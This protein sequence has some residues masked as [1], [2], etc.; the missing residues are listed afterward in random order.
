MTLKICGGEIV[1]PAGDKSGKL[2]ILIEDGRIKAIG[3]DL[4]EASQTIDAGGKMIF[5]G[6]IDIHCHLREPGQEY[7]EDIISGTKAAA[8]GGYTAV[9]P[10]PNTSPVMD[11]AAV[12]ALVMERAKQAYTKVYPVGAATAGLM[13]KELTE[14]GELAAMGCVAFSDDGRPIENGAMMRT[15]MQYAATYGAFIMAHEECLDLKGKG[16]M[17]E[18]YYSTILGL[19][20][21]PRAAEEAM[22]ARDIILAESYGLRVHIQHVSTRGGIEIIRAAK[23]RGVKVTSET[24]PHYFSGDDSLCRGYD[25]RAKVNPPLRTCDDVEAVKQGLLD[26]TIDAIATDHAPHHRDEKNIEFALAA[27]GISGFETAFSLAVTNLTDD[28]GLLARL[29][30]ANPANII[31]KPGGVLKEGAAADITI[32][33]M[34]IEYILKEEDI[35]SKGKNTPFIGQKLKGVVTQ[36]IVDGKLVFDGEIL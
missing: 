14:M 1:N 12:C 35:I 17:N 4:G 30:A 33:D 18:G 6:F 10:M 31:G 8:R 24:A 22:I 25:A 16:V 27:S 19:P 15:A 26:G 9:C 32:A 5:P 2:D 36:T 13:G 3:K 20:G 21:I 29:F 11:N 23:K 34:N 7:K 28:A